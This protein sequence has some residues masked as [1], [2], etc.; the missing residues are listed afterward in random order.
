MQND[1]SKACRVVGAGESSS[2]E[3]DSAR[4]ADWERVAVQRQK[5]EEQEDTR[6]GP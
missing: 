4:E 3:V 2:V 5:K 1:A 6:K